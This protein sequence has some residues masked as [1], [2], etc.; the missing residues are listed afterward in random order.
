MEKKFFYFLL[1]LNLLDIFKSQNLYE[2]NEKNFILTKSDF[3]KSYKF[4]PKAS[5]DLEHE[6][7]IQI[8]SSNSQINIKMCTG[9]FK[10]ANEQ[11]I[12]YDYSTNQFI[13]CQK[14]FSATITDYAEFN[15]DDSFYPIDIDNIKEYYY[16]AVYIDK[17]EVDE[18]SGSIMPIITNKEIKLNIDKIY[19]YYIFKNNYK[20][21]NFSFLIPL[22]FFEKQNLHIQLATNNNENIFDIIL[23]NDQNDIIDIK[24]SINSY[25]Y[26]LDSINGPNN[27]YLNISFLKESTEIQDKEFAI[28]FEYTKLNNNI[29]ELSNDTYAINFLTNNVYYFAQNLTNTNIN[30]F[31]L[32]HAH[33]YFGKKLNVSSAKINYSNFSLDKISKLDFSF[34]RSKTIF[35]IFS[36]YNYVNNN[37]SNTSDILIL[38]LSGSGLPSLKLHTIQFKPLQKIII[39]KIN[40]LA[41]YSFNS[42]SNIENIGYFYIPSENNETKRQLIYCSESKTMGIFRGDYHISDNQYIGSFISNNFRLYKISHE[43]GINPKDN[44]DG[45][46]IITFNKEKSYY[47]QI[48]DISEEI[49][50][51]LMIETISDINHL[52]REIKLK[53]PAQYYYVF[54]DNDFTSNNNDI[55]FDAKI[56]FGS[57]K[58][59]FLD[60]DNIK[61]KDFN[62]NKILLFQK[63]DY[64]IIDINHPILIKKSTELIKITNNYYS[65][66]VYGAKLYLNKYFNHIDN[67]ISKSLVPIYLNSYDSKRYLLEILGDTKY[68]LK[69]GDQYNDY[70]NCTNAT[71]IN[72]ILGNDEINNIYNISNKNNFIKIND[73]HIY[74]GDTIKF[75]NY[76]DKPILIWCY[77]GFKDIEQENIVS[78]YL[79]KDYYYLYK[80]NVRHKLTLD[81][82]NIK[83]KINLGIIPQK[84]E[85]SILNDRQTRATGYYYQKISFADDHDDDYL[86][87]YSYVN[88]I[89][90]ELEEGQS[91]IF[92]EGN[93]NITA[94]DEYFSGDSLVNFVI[95]PESGLTSVL[96]YMEYSFD[97]SNYVNELKY[98]EF[99]NSIYSLNLKP[100]IPIIN[101]VDSKINS[102]YLAFQCL[103]C[104]HRDSEKELKINFKFNT[105]LEIEQKDN[106]TIK[107]IT[108]YNILGYLNLEKFDRNLLNNSLYINII[109]PN[110]FYIRYQYVSNLNKNYSFQ[111]DYNINIEKEMNAGGK[112]FA[113]S[114]DPFI[115]N[116]K[117]NYT[118]LITNKNEYKA[119]IQTECDFFNLLENQ[120]KYENISYINFIDNND[121]LRIKKDISFERTGNYEIFIMAQSISSHSIYKYLGSETYSYNG[122]FKD[123]DKD[124][125]ALLK[126][127]SIDITLLTVI[128]L[129]SLFLI[130]IIILTFFYFKKKKKLKN[131]YKSLNETMLSNKMNN[132]QNNFNIISNNSTIANS[133][134]N[135]LKEKEKNIELIDKP[136]IEENEIIKDEEENEQNLICQPP[137]PIF[138]NTGNTFFSEEDR[139]KFEFD[140]LRHAPN[141]NKNQK[142]EDKKYVNTNMGEG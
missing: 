6:I 139:I 78:L 40:N 35:D 42:E 69:L 56:V 34:I 123:K 10:N 111:N 119:F 57:V 46:T 82:Y 77:F 58:I 18:F 29:I 85:I 27:Y 138:E 127:N 134:G 67:K 32:I 89:S 1:L 16:I 107:S 88:S 109:K 50:N 101:R 95:F 131:L 76:L 39:D 124:D 52:N 28:H 118:I 103:I 142:N 45:Y 23:F 49:Y 61:E 126:D 140:K 63:E 137:A 92:L 36:I 71:I 70:T 110:Q 12:F 120:N 96:F 25:N 41:H 24:T 105:N 21:S 64:S 65:N 20:T 97:I 135:D 3:F 55:I 74:F 19:K 22:I 84:I 9:Y 8:K 51:N 5:P 108:T 44:F 115:K 99:D 30:L 130:L 94:Y 141:I 59:E 79:S 66:Y 102:N 73:S 43:K 98:L 136:N 75:N 104:S 62:L 11:N 48:I 68:F 132:S 112:L 91:H 72:I 93:V 86:L 90:Y 13:N 33:D 47:I 17:L 81:W 26:F 122:D 133:N 83:S 31:Y 38:K 113:I 106:Y 15:I 80:L 100:Y 54:Y 114:F 7:I 116:V 60:I 121:K 117:T 87:Y 4:F 128:I 37:I 53:L 125:K 14:N 2:Y 129:S